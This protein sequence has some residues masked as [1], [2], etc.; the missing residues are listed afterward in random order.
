MHQALRSG[1]AP[2]FVSWVLTEYCN[3]RCEYC[4]CPDIAARELRGDRCLQLVDEMAALGTRRI[5][6]TGGEPL[7]R[8]DLPALIERARSRG[9]AVALNTNGTLVPARIDALREA[10]SVSLSLDGP[11]AI[12]D[13][14][15]GVGQTDEV[16]AAC[17]ALAAAGVPIHLQG[18]LTS[19]TTRAAVDYV[20]DITERFG[21]RAAFQPALELELGTQ[22]PNPVAVQTIAVRRL[23]AYVDGCRAIGRPVA[24][25]TAALRHLATFPQVRPLPCLVGRVACRLDPR[26]QLTPC[27]ERAGSVQAADAAGLGF[28]AAWSQ[29]RP[30]D[31][32][33][34]WGS[35]RAELRAATRLRPTAV[36]GLLRGAL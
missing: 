32:D 24:Q 6:F 13:A 25:S 9:I 15:R 7:V 11:P 5:K 23:L 4:A 29:I 28:A 8:K 12:H 19:R 31:C 36:L 10:A 3:L 27:H 26:G 21:A 18:L 1:R 33:E 14:H 22:R 16:L 2:L 17:E 20:L 34:C 30:A 35:G